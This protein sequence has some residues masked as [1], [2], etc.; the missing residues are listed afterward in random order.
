H[1]V[2]LE[3]DR[4]LGA[5]AVYLLADRH[6]E[7]AAR[8]ELGALAVGGGYVQFRQDAYQAGALEGTQRTFKA[9][10]VAGRVLVGQGAAAQLAAGDGE[11]R[12]L[13]QGQA[14]A[15]AGQ[16]GAGVQSELLHGGALDL[17]DPGPDRDLVRALDGHHVDDLFGRGDEGA[18]DLA[19][20][21]GLAGAEDRPRQDDA[22]VDRLGVD[23]GAR[24]DPAEGVLQGRDP[25]VDADAQRQDGA[26]GVVQNDRVG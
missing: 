13:G 23:S 22:A 26:A 5:V 1:A 14:I 10:A 16:H 17:D 12:G 8:E 24:H 25:G 18:G 6:G 21:V 11:G 9:A 3:L 7:L 19:G 4:H 20:S 15:D 2:G